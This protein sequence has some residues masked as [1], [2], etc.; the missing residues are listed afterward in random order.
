[1]GLDELTV[2]VVNWGTPDLTLRCVRTLLDD[3]VPPGRVVLVD[4]G[5]E[6]G[7]YARFRAE[8]PDCVHLRLEQNAGY[9]RAANAGARA[10]EGEAHLFLNNDAFVHRP[11]S[12]AALVRCLADDGVGIAVPRVLNDDLSLQP[13]VYPLQTPAVAFVL[14]TGAGRLLPNGRQPRWGRHWDHGESRP[15][16]AA[17]A[18]V[19]LVRGEVWRSL[20]GFHESLLSY[21]ED[22]DLCWRARAGGWKIWFTTDA[23]FVHLRA[24]T[25]GR[26]YGELERAEMVARAEVAMIRRNLP[27]LA[28]QLSLG[29]IAC[30]L[31]G[32]SAQYA[33]AGRRDASA[34]TRA[35]LRGHLGGWAAR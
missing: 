14:A 17:S 2:V 29:S 23:E 19:M 33:A 15:V 1:V 25:T 31:A 3:G 9:V 21:S 20:G 34:R 35:A 32:R 18:V 27:P 4:N 5:S 24:G 8:L 13:T 11:G 30:G 26:H 10:L 6:D 22:I 28:A 12:V 7:S 16:E